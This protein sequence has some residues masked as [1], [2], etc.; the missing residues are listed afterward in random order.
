MMKFGYCILLSVFIS[1]V[2]G[3]E[4]QADQ[5]STVPA[6]KA[7]EKIK[8]PVE[9]IEPLVDPATL[10]SNLYQNLEL[11]K[12]YQAEMVVNETEKKKIY[13]HTGEGNWTYFSIDVKKT[14]GSQL[15]VSD[16]KSVLS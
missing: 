6:T 12:Y 9:K 10:P 15:K 16:P 1:I 8:P 13:N 7:V 11:G 2:L 5:N 3:R 4:L 14:L